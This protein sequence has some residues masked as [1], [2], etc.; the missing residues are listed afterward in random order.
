MIRIPLN[1]D[2]VTAL[3]RQNT[4]ILAQIANRFESGIMIEYGQTTVNAK[5]VLGLLTAL[6]N[7]DREALMIAAD[8]AD[9]ENAVRAITDFLLTLTV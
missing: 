2:T 4:V 7:G 5:S 6:S 3:N 8:G 9:E 1:P